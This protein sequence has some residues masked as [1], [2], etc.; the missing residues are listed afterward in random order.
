MNR[1]MIIGNLAR[2]PELR[3]TPSGANVCNFTVAVNRKGKGGQQPETDWFNVSA[4]NKLA[5]NCDKYLDKG[6]KVCVVG[7][8]SVRTYEGN[9]GKTR[10]QLEVMANEVEFLSGRN[11]DSGDGY[12]SR[13]AQDTGYNDAQ[14]APAQDTG[15]SD[16]NNGYTHVDMNDDLPF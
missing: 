11:D 4:W 15:Y 10:A 6:K 8:V 7:P 5:E 12:S 14:S 9:D 2:K 16:E 13:P 1:L 3:T